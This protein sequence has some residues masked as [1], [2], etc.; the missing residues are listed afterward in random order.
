VRPLAPETVERLRQ[1]M[2]PRDA[3]LVSVLAYA[4][5]RP[6]EALALTWG[7]VRERT[8]LVEQSASYGEIKCTK[9][10]STRSVRMLAPLKHDLAEHRI[11]EGRPLPERFVFPAHDGRR[12]DDDWNNWRNRVFRPAVK[13]AGLTD[14]RP[15]DL[16]H[17]FVSLLIAEGR[18]IVE[19]AR[20]AGIRRRC[21]STPTGTSSTS[22]TVPRRWTQ[23]RRSGPPGSIGATWVLPQNAVSS[24]TRAT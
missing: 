13:E 10:R 5:L 6:G 22:S 8:I 17:S 24:P 20:Q 4:G 15:Y 23:K 12:W 7:H 16:R 21:R 3:V 14:V 19:V 2:P 9:T 1:A 11:R 18:S